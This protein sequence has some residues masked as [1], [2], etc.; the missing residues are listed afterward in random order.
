M[1]PWSASECIC[2]GEANGQGG[3]RGESLW[4]ICNRVGRVLCP[5]RRRGS[6]GGGARHW[7][8]GL[9]D[10]VLC[11]T[12]PKEWCCGPGRCLRDAHFVPALS[13]RWLLE[14]QRPHKQEPPRCP[15]CPNRG[16]RRLASLPPLC[17]TSAGLGH[18]DQVPARWRVLGL[19]WRVLAEEL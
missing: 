15:P 10:S 5:P 1:W 2:A 6:S 4:W 16:F 7:Q 12:T 3:R 8:A 11:R 18:G 19:G 14:E 17:R 13:A 9:G